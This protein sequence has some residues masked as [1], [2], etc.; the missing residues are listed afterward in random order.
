MKMEEEEK[1]IEDSLLKIKTEK[2]SL[3]INLKM[4]LWILIP[5]DLIILKIKQNLV[6]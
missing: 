2:K 4:K 3:K 1:H 5:I 6:N